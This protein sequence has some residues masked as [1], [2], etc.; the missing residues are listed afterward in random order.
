[1]GKNKKQIWLRKLKMKKN[2]KPFFS[3]VVCTYNRALIL[4]NCLN[5]L[6]NQSLAKKR[7]EILIMDDGSSD[8][9][10]ALLKDYIKKHN[11]P[12]I[13]LYSSPNIGLAHSRNKAVKQ[14]TGRFIAYIDDDAKADINWLEN[15]YKR[16]NET[17]NSPV[18]L[19]GPILTYYRDKK[20]TWFKDKYEEDTKGKFSRFLKIGETFSGPNMILKKDI[21]LKNGGF[22]EDIDMKADVLM[23]GEETKFYEQIWQNNPGGRLLYYAADVKVYHLVHPYKMKVLYR[24]KRWFASGQSYFLRNQSNSPIAKILMTLKVITYFIISSLFAFISLFKVQYIQNWIIESLGP[25]AFVFGYFASLF[26]LPV[27]MLSKAR[28]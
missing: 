2:N 22:A 4:K 13:R 12:L 18:G 11:N 28:F 1:M 14:A 5:S 21:I 16:L 26:N 3:V 7:Y 27:R 8:E 20:P 15:A 24:L 10:V 23:V 17:K 9:T 19:T 25:L 6:L